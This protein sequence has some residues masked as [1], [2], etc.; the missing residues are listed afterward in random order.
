MVC[1]GTEKQGQSETADKFH[2]NML[3]ILTRCEGDFR[4]TRFRDPRSYLFVCRHCISGAVSH[5][6]DFADTI[7]REL[8]TTAAFPRLW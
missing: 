3:F 2:S 4:R 8:G 1:S 7:L 5:F 6:S